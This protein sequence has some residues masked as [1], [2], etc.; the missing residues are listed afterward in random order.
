MENEIGN[1]CTVFVVTVDDSK[2]LTD[3][4]RYGRLRGVFTRQR[5]PY[6]TIRLI[7]QARDTLSAF[8]PGDSLL[9]VGDPTL[10]AVCLSIVL[11]HHGR[12]QILQWDKLAFGYTAQTWDFDHPTQHDASFIPVD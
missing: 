12:V 10:C 2:D 3:A 1:T 6:N 5:R 8:Q 9:M 4:K 11:E 7:Q